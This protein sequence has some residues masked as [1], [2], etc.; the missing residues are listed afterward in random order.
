MHGFVVRDFSTE[1]TRFG[2]DTLVQEWHD[3]LLTQCGYTEPDHELVARLAWV[4]GQALSNLLHEETGMMWSPVNGTFA[5]PVD[6]FA[7]NGFEFPL[8]REQL[9]LIWS[10]VFTTVSEERFEDIEGGLFDERQYGITC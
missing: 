5:V 6:L 3:F 2:W 8:T 7:R 1:N 9:D 4:N 10:D